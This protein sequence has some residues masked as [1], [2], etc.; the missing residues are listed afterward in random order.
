MRAAMNTPTAPQGETISKD[1][2]SPITS[3]TILGIVTMLLAW[4]N[5][6]FNLGIG[7][8]DG[9]QTT[10]D[11]MTIVGL[12]VG[13][14]GRYTAKQPIARPSSSARLWLGMLLLDLGIAAA[15]VTIAI[16]IAV[17][18]ATN[19]T[20]CVTVQGEA[21]YG[22]EGRQACVTETGLKGKIKEGDA[23]ASATVLWPWQKAKPAEPVVPSAPAPSPA[24]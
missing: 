13:I 5:T 18:V 23:S 24:P 17:F 11:I 3:K 14:W 12:A 16:L 1:P 9:E 19:F 7:G 22:P 6:K 21:C 2:K 10:S 15:K 4:L 20:G 8:E